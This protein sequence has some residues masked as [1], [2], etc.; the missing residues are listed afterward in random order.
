MFIHTLN[1]CVIQLCC[2]AYGDEN[3]LNNLCSFCGV[4]QHIYEGD[5][6]LSKFLEFIIRFKRK[7]FKNFICIAHNAKAFD[8][9]FILKY[10][11]E[12]KKEIP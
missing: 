6:S 1:L 8:A 9:Q 2:D 4:R 7:S 12:N 5:D 3:N 11:V 10:I